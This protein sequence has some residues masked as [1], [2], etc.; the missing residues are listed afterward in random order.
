[1]SHWGQ[2]KF[3]FT[4]MFIEKS[5]TFH[6]TLVQIGELIGCRGGKKGIFS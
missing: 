2:L 6:M 3:L 4:K 1:M 5:S